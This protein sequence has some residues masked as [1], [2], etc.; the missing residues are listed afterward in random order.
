MAVPGAVSTRERRKPIPS[1][2][3]KSS[4]LITGDL[5][6]LAILIGISRAMF[7]SR[8]QRSFARTKSAFTD[9]GRGRSAERPADIPVKGWK[10]IAWRVY[11]G[12]QN[13][14]VLLVSAGVTF[15]ALLA[16][17]P[18]TAATLS[19][20]GLFADASAIN[21]HLRLISGFLPEG[22]LEVIGDQVRRI[23]S[24]PQGALGAAFFGSLALSLWGANAGTKAIFDAL[25]IAYKEQEKRG[26]IGLTITSFVFTLSAIILVVIAMAGIVVAPVALALLGIPSQSLTAWLTM[27]RWPFLYL[28]ILFAL[29]CL[30]R[31]G[32]SRTHPQW[33][34]VT[35]GSTIAGGVWI[36]GSLLLSWY[37][38]HFGTYNATYGSL[39]A[40]VG[41][42]I[43]IWLSTVIV[44]AGA[45]INAEM[46]H[47]T[48][49]DT[50][51]GGGKPLG[52]RGAR[53]WPM[54]SGRRA[55]SEPKHIS[56]I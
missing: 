55:P 16:L 28:A 5:I 56:G 29:A 45:E 41:F 12:L 48:A 32:P 1:N 27:L 9:G 11:L 3:L 6:A 13:D 22:A 44:V 43:W 19:L 51:E 35:W 8:N 52:T 39:G 18:A 26:F 38:A 31:Y 4:R 20:Y 10:D 36:V 24:Q 21:K 37:V 30:Y 47:Q 33:Q 25:N 2:R 54:R 40:V 7:G 49:R 42:M 46:E 23:T 15:Y 50:T 53:E 14:R 17:F 34:W